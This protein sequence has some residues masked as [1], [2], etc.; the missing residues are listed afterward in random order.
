MVLPVAYLCVDSRVGL[1]FML[2]GGELAHYEAM[3]MTRDQQ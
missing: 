3:C 1:H 2:R